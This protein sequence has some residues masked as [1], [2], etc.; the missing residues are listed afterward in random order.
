MLHCMLR[1]S[2]K[3]RLQ[4]YIYEGFPA[5]PWALDSCFDHEEPAG[6]SLTPASNQTPITIKTTK[7]LIPIRAESNTSVVVATS[8]GAR[9][10]VT[11]PLKPYSAK[12][13]ADMAGGEMRAIRVRDVDKPVTKK[14]ANI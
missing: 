5:P 12:N 6:A 11:E 14:T 2:L 4:Q 10:A 8:K 7:A 3:G 13:C 9:K 1:G